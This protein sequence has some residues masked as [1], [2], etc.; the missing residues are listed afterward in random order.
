MEKKVAFIT[1]SSKLNWKGVEFRKKK[2]ER[3]KRP[4]QIKLKSKNLKKKAK[5][6]KRLEMLNRKNVEKCGFRHDFLQNSTEKSS[7]FGKKGERE[8]KSFINK[9]KKQKSAK[10]KFKN[11]N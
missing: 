5:P 11:F 8:E 6:V 1:I 9:I 2:V 4:S 3:Q 10:P 7:N